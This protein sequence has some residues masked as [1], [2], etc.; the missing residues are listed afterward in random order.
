MGGVGGVGGSDGLRRVNCHQIWDL[1]LQDTDFTNGLYKRAL[2][3]YRFLAAE[4]PSRHQ[5][6]GGY[7]NT[8]PHHFQVK[9]YHT[10]GPNVTNFQFMSVGQRW[11]IF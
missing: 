6:G 11:F 8:T 1:Q 4:A 5:G 9:S 3:G 7:S 10:H 2:A